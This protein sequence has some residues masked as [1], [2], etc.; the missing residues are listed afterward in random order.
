[1]LEKL[2]ICITGS[3]Q[4]TPTK[5]DTPFR[6]GKLTNWAANPTNL[7]PREMEN[8]RT[9]HERSKISKEGWDRKASDIMIV[10]TQVVPRKT[11]V[12]KSDCGLLRA[13][14]KEIDVVVI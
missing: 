4:S 3:R 9:I 1:M 2:G 8:D 10:D 6:C 13:V 5:S 12:V 14:H 7:L 11:L